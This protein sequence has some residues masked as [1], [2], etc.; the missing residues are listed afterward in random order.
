VGDGWND[1]AAE[2]SARVIRGQLLKFADWNWTY[3][4][5]SETLEKGTRLIAIGTAAAWVKWQ[6]G[7]PTEYRMKVSGKPLPNREEL[8][9]TDPEKW[10]FG[11]D[12]KPRRDPWQATRFIYLVHPETGEAFT[13]STSSFGGRETVINLADSIARVRS[14][15]HAAAV[16]VVAL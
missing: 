10:E 15:G 8:G 7:K 12:E 3:G 5:E 16:P 9:D 14:A 11:P 1:A 13:F 4:K 2:A 6:D